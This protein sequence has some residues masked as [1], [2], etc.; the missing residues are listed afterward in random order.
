MQESQP[1]CERSPVQGQKFPLYRSQL[2]I[3][4]SA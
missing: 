2:Y 4:T 3:L 1:Y